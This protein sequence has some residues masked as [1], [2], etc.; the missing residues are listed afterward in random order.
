[1][2]DKMSTNLIPDDIKDYKNEPLYFGSFLIENNQ[3]YI[4]FI[5]NGR[6]RGWGLKIQYNNLNYSFDAGKAF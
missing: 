5:E 6:P 4:G 3:V 1:M 2:I